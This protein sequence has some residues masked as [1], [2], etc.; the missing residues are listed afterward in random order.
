MGPLP[1]P[2]PP[3]R[4]YGGPGR[5]R[6]AHS[7]RIPPPP[8]PTPSPRA[9]RAASCAAPA[10]FGAAARGAG[11]LF[12]IP[13]APKAVGIR[14]RSSERRG[15]PTTRALSLQRQVR[16]WWGAG[17]AP[18]SR[19]AYSPRARPWQLGE[20]AAIL[21]EPAP[22]RGAQRRE[23][24]GKV[25]AAT[26]AG[27]ARGA[28]SGRTG[29]LGSCGGERRRPLPGQL[30][31]APRSTVWRFQGASVEERLQKKEEQENGLDFW[32]CVGLASGQQPLTRHST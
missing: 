13:S 23:I 31:R 32:R 25:E 3:G 18:P 11:R 5:G 30:S 8:F 15:R 1:A 19:P 28:G 4:N 24:P 17:V 10:R 20:E 12:A 9:V 2:P 14:A 29:A 27:R 16:V 6:R 26:G 21:S 22:E 7:C